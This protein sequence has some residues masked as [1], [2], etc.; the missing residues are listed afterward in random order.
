[1]YLLFYHYML[2]KLF[3][4]MLKS[5]FITKL[6]KKKLSV[7]TEHYKLHIMKNNYAGVIYESHQLIVGTSQLMMTIV[8]CNLDHM[9]I[10]GKTSMSQQV[11]IIFKFFA[12]LKCYHLYLI[13]QCIWFCFWLLLLEY[14]TITSYITTKYVQTLL[15]C[16]NILLFLIKIFFFRSLHKTEH[17]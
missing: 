1:M 8:R 10:D 6:V 15:R 9:I 14:N 12:W 5:Y 13:Y 7:I 16:R 4:V 17:A 2:Q 3:H 11:I